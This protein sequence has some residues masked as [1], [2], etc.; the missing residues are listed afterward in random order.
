M[1]CRL[2]AAPPAVWAIR[3]CS[4]YRRATVVWAIRSCGRWISSGPPPQSMPLPEPN[5]IDTTTRAEKNQRI[6]RRIESGEEKNITQTDKNIK[7]HV[8]LNKVA[9]TFMTNYIIVMVVRVSSVRQA[10]Q[11][12]GKRKYTYYVYIYTYICIYVYI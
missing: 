7:M 2:V 11:A 1:S 9:S 4:T 5:R 6:Q 3:V 12:E 10:D 8:Y